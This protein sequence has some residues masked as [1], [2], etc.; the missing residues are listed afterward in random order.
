MLVFTGSREST[1][2][3]DQDLLY[4]AGLTRVKTTPLA[5]QLNT[6]QAT[7]AQDGEHQQ[8]PELSRPGAAALDCP[9]PYAGP[10]AESAGTPLGS[11]HG[12][13]GMGSGRRGLIG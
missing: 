9:S 4:R 1:E 13:L 10:V 3:E 11:R 2:G 7:P 5:S 6:F 8:F 12:V